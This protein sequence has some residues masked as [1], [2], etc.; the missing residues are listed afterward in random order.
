MA[1]GLPGTL[2][3]AGRNADVYDIGDGRVLRRYRDGREAR[4]VTLEAQ[5]MMHA[6][7]FT[8]S[9]AHAAGP[10]DRAW[11]AT[12][13]RH[14]LNDRNLLPTERSRLERLPPG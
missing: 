6:R 8:R 13:I 10:I 3:G 1:G 14:R 2:I 7:A 4:R 5:V 9:F 12:A 11:R